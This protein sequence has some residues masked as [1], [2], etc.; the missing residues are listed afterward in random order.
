V[1]PARAIAA[2]I[3]AEPFAP[4]RWLRGAHLQTCAAAMLPRAPRP[5]DASWLVRTEPGTLVRCDANMARSP[6]GT[7]LVVVH[8]LLRGLHVVRMNMRNCGGTEHLTPTLY[9][10]KLDQDL[11]AVVGDLA[12][13]GARRIVLAG[14]SIGGNLVL[15]A[16]AHWGARPP[17][18]LCGAVV[19]CPAID[20]GACVALVDA[21]NNALYRRYFVGLLRR[22]YA[23]K[24]GLFPER[25]DP[26]RLDEVRTLRDYDRVASAPDAGFT[27]L[28][29]FYAWV[30]SSP[31]LHAIRVPTVVV[32]AADDPV[33]RVLPST[34]AAIVRND[35]MARVELPNGGHCGFLDG[36]RPWIAE[37]VAR[38]AEAW[39]RTPTKRDRALD[40]E[41]SDRDLRMPE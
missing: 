41:R 38:A 11:R 35:A 28:D 3:F 23:R 37:R 18:A 4:P 24:A 27:D 10:S 29:A 13:R 34:C 21:P 5:P 32:H 36:G 1:I 16:L 20:V 31:R 22:F 14:Y 40:P 39:S 9:H 12:E 19:S 25:F 33:V 6:A 2:S 15:N 7:T 30:S 26:D 8:G 17:P